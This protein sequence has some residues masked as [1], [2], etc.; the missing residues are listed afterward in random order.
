MCT[1][2]WSK[3]ILCLLKLASLVFDLPSQCFNLPLQS[4]VVSS[5][6]LGSLGD[7]EKTTWFLILEGTW[8][9]SFPNPVVLLKKTKRRTSSL[10]TPKF[11]LLPLLPNS[12]GPG[13]WRHLRQSGT[14][15]PCWW[16]WYV[17]IFVAQALANS[18]ALKNW[19]AQI[20]PA[21]KLPKRCLKQLPNSRAADQG[22]WD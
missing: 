20:G 4:Y 1:R 2:A 7:L 9:P 14:V 21:F 17:L 18:L 16:F 13:V 6:I 5:R 3:L 11:K 15:A 19:A 10:L 22:L 12:E 8:S